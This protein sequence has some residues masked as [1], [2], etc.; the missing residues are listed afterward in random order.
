MNCDKMIEFERNFNDLP[1]WISFHTLFPRL[2]VFSTYW[3][4]WRMYERIQNKSARSWKGEIK[5]RGVEA[6]LKRMRSVF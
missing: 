4:F 5:M 2:S 3:C 6:S 1:F